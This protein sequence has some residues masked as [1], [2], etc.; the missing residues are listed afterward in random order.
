MNIDSDWS[1]FG[2]PGL[3]LDSII[4]RRPGGLVPSLESL[5]INRLIDSQNITV[6]TVLSGFCFG[7]PVLVWNTA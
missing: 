4:T 5:D 1:E 6:P 7:D 2:R 3:K